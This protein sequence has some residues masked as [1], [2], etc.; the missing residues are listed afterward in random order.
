M[1]FLRK[2]GIFLS[3]QI[4]RTTSDFRIRHCPVCDYEVRKR[5]VRKSPPSQ[6]GHAY[7]FWQ[8]PRFVGLLPDV[9]QLLRNS[10]NHSIFA[11]SP[12]VAM[13]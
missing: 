2:T 9:M 7:K 3:D 13:G 12:S 6:I 8:F 1:Y 5:A 4:Y 10:F 11:I